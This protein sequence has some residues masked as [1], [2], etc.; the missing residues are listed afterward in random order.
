MAIDL[1][2]IAAF[3][4]IFSDLTNVGAAISSLGGVGDKERRT[5]L[6]EQVDSLSHRLYRINSLHAQTLQ[7]CA[8][9]ESEV[10]ELR[11]FEVERE[12]YVLHQWPSG[13][14]TYR[15]KPEAQGEEPD[16]HLC[17]ACYAQAVKSLL[18]PAGIEKGHR[19]LRCQKCH[20]VYLI[21]V[22]RMQ[23]E[24]F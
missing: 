2:T 7:H 23:C 16:H 11:Y 4:G 5:Q 6:V 22:Q 10:V 8:A 21:E 24:T 18:Q 14:L 12:R 19:A 3:S 17:P 13:A 9:L 20:E 15:V 1:S